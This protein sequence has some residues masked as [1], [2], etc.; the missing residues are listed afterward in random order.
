MARVLA[1]GARLSIPASPLIPADCRPQRGFSLA[2]QQ[3]PRRQVPRSRTA[4]HDLASPRQHRQHGLEQQLSGDTETRLTCLSCSRYVIDTRFRR[5]AHSRLIGM[6]VAAAAAAAGDMPSRC[7]VVQC[8]RMVIGR[9]CELG[10]PERALLPGCGRQHLHSSVFPGHRA[11]GPWPAPA[12]CGATVCTRGS[13]PSRVMGGSPRRPGPGRPNAV[14]IPDG[15]MVSPGCS[16][17]PGS[18]P[19]AGHTGVRE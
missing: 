8:R 1:E 14:R 13:G 19:S 3:I 17:G 11:S 16:I 5:S 9:G 15:A 2:P 7:S 10:A 4:A 18:P 12:A 6:P